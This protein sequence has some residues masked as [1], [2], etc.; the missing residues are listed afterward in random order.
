[1][2][3]LF[4]IGVFLA[5]F[6]CILLLSKKD[7]KLSDKLL[8]V[9]M[10]IIG[11]N[12]LDY[13]LYDSGLWINHT[14][15]IGLGA[16]IPFLHGIMLYLY[17]KFSLSTDLTLNKKDSI[18]FLP[19]SVYYLAISPFFFFNSNQKLLELSNETSYFDFVNAIALIGFCISGMVYSIISFRLL[20]K[21]YQVIKQNFSYQEAINHNWLKYCV[22]GLFVIFIAVITVLILQNI[23]K[24][25]ASF[26]LEFIFYSFVIVYI[27]FIGFCGIHY[28]GLFNN[29]EPREI[30]ELDNPFEE[31]QKT[32]LKQEEAAVLHEKL[33]T[34]MADKKPYLEQ[35]L[36][37]S[38][39][40]EMLD[41][42]LHHLS[43]IINQ[44]E[45]KNFYDFINC[46]R[47]EEFKSRVINPKYDSYSLLGIALDSGFNS[48]STFNQVFKKATGE[49]PSGYKK[50]IFSKT[51]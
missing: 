43:Q 7:K 22:V 36:T 27:F 35:R 2:K 34:L 45:N 49:T 1:M 18:H 32:G 5:Y 29:P 47:V 41:I 50:R 16:G 4:T 28:R 48:K 24:F 20:M 11:T 10:F 51:V 42:S 38:E 15:L 46:Y 25:R 14:F 44:Y 6:L 23:F 21:E 33:L 31:Y 19:F 8:A 17:V 12:L 3:I 39:L 30:L 9:W 13:Y 26:N 40:S 37:L